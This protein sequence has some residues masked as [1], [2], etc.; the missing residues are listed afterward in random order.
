M[1]S[2]P[3]VIFRHSKSKNISSCVSYFVCKVNYIHLRI[4]ELQKNTLNICDSFTETRNKVEA[5]ILKDI[6]NGRLNFVYLIR[7]LQYIP[8]I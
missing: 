5:L 2:I 1:T 4:M 6:E 3:F 7:D 8:N